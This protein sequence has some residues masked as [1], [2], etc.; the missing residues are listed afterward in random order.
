MFVSFGSSSWARTS[1]IMINS[2]ALYR[3]SYRGI[4]IFC[5]VFLT[6]V[7]ATLVTV[8]VCT[9]FY[10]LCKSSGQS[11]FTLSAHSLSSGSV[12][13]S[14]AVAHQV[15]STLRSLTSVFGMGTGGTSSLWPP[16]ILLIRD[17]PS[18]LNNNRLLNSLENLWSSPRP[19][20]INQLHTLLHFHLWPINLIVYKGSY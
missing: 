1:D 5:C 18:K 6:L 4:S 19:I 2:H 8:I 17:I 20:S 3:L 12:L 14:R 11:L 16:D 13:S 7:F 9:A 10:V 15:L